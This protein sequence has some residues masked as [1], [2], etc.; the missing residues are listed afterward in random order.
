M[1][2][3]EKQ[4]AELSVQFS[5]LS[6]ELEKLQPKIERAEGE[7]LRLL[8]EGVPFEDGHFKFW[9]KKEAALLSMICTRRRWHWS[10]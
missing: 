7:V 6:V 10:R 8:E 3:I 5:S 4:M 9:Q 1:D 2:S